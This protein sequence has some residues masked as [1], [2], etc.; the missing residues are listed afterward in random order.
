MATVT[1]VT[2]GY[3]AINS[4]DL[5]SY[6]TSLSFSVE[7]EDLDSTAFGSGGYR[8]HVGGLKQGTIEATFNNDF[9]DNL[10]DEIQWALL[11]T[12]TTFEVRAVGT[13]VTASN[14]K[15]TGSALIASWTPVSAG[16]GEL[17]QV[18]VSWVTSGTVTRGT[19]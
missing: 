8:S 15:Y 19:T 1:A 7:A 5:S 16:V 14:P 6:C 2:N 4:V 18:Q 17:A 11:G 13:T 10:L 12:V 3:I 9:T